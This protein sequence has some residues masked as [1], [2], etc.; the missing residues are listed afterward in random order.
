MFGGAAIAERLRAPGSARAAADAGT[1]TTRLVPSVEVTSN[2]S[3]ASDATSPASRSRRSRSVRRWI[4]WRD[5]EKKAP[6]SK[7]AGRDGSARGDDD[8]LGLGASSAESR[9]ARERRGCRRSGVRVRV[10]LVRR[11]AARRPRRRFRGVAAARHGRKH[12]MQSAAGRARSGFRRVPR[13]S[14]SAHV[15]IAS[16]VLSPPL[17]SRR[18]WSGTTALRQAPPTRS[19]LAAKSDGRQRTR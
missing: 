7:E 13:R 6:F 8:V 9:R 2:T 16:V 4:D 3:G 1:A 14:G 5:F 18:R 19:R 15:P 17:S 11:L 10:G 12:T